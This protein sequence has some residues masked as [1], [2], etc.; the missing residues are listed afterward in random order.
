MTRD[1]MPGL[2]LGE[3]QALEAIEFGLQASTADATEILVAAENTDLTRFAN[4]AIHQNV[5]ETQ[6]QL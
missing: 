4:L 1:Q 5:T 2:P 3:Q 6:Y